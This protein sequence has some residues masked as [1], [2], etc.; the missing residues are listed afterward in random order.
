MKG[1]EGNDSYK[2]LKWKQRGR[3]KIWRREG[4]ARHPGPPFRTGTGALSA[5]K[6][7]ARAQGP[8]SLTQLELLREVEELVQAE[9]TWTD[10]LWGCKDLAEE[11]SQGMMGP[12]SSSRAQS[13]LWAMGYKPE[14]EDQS[15]GTK[16]S[17]CR[18]LAGEATVGH[19]MACWSSTAAKFL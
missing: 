3:C 16:G 2:T 19:S 1:G 11:V 6:G 13:M 12:W 5:S 4:P 17:G 7:K 8:V 18:N 14:K 15:W 9:E 10:T